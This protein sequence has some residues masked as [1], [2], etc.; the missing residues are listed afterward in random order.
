MSIKDT[1]VTYKDTTDSLIRICQIY[2]LNY[3]NISSLMNKGLSFEDA[4]NAENLYSKIFE[5]RGE[6]GN[7]TFFAKRYNLSPSTIHSKLLSTNDS[8]ENILEKLISTSSQ[9]Y[10]YNGTVGTFE[11]ICEKNNINYDAAR[12]LV[13]N[14][15]TPYEAFVRSPRNVVKTKVNSYHGIKGS[16]A[17]IV[18]YFFPLEEEFNN[19]YPVIMQRM[20]LGASLEDAMDKS[21]IKVKSFRYVNSD[22]NTTKG[23]IEKIAKE[24]GVNEKT[25]ISAYVKRNR[26]MDYAIYYART[27]ALKN[28]KRQEKADCS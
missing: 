19:V 14:G 5:F 22:G 21:L 2:D 23:T 12:V 3:R 1:L 11:D 15:Y 10:E 28:R 16:V 17:K 7:I 26:S 8:L 20:R 6:K 24:F 27:K 9:E 18:R 25:L 4:L 13:E